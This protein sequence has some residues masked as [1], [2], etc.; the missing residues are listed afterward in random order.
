MSSPELASSS[1]PD[2]LVP[3]EGCSQCGEG[4]D[5]QQARLAHSE[6]DRDAIWC[7]SHPPSQHLLLPAL[8]SPPLGCGEGE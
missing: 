1:R 6:A 3:G 5:G 2:S 7:T 8:S 4:L